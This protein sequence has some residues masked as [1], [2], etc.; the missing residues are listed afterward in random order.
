MGNNERGTAFSLYILIPRTQNLN[1]FKEDQHFLKAEKL[2]M[3]SNITRSREIFESWQI[4]NIRKLI[5]LIAQEFK[6]PS[7]LFGD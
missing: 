4:L 6:M 5:S 3:K 2:K 1:I 7:R